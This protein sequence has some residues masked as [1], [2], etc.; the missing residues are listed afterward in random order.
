M[1]F[2]YLGLSMLLLLVALPCGATKPDAELRQSIEHLGALVS[3]GYAQLDIQRIASIPAR[4]RDAVAV[5]FTLESPGKGNGVW[6]FL[7]FLRRNASFAADSPPAS[8]YRLIAFKQVGAR[9]TKLFD[10][11]TATYAN[12]ALIVSGKGYGPKDAMCCPSLPLRSTFTLQH[13]VVVEQGSAP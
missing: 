1:R 13:D 5:I 6:Q 2:E 3:D 8:A 4:D 12:G 10:P 11:E 7:A 9:G